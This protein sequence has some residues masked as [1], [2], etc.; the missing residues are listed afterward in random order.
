M[1]LKAYAC[2]D[3]NVCLKLTPPQ[4]AV[5]GAKATKGAYCYVIDVSGRQA[6]SLRSPRRC[7]EG[8]LLPSQTQF[9][10]PW[11]ADWTA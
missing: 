6:S 10:S 2:A 4:T 3:G 9:T 7:A 5:T 1:D 8:P 11:P